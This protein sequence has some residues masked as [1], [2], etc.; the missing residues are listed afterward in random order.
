MAKDKEQTTG[1]TGV[2]E[3][4]PKQDTVVADIEQRAEAKEAKRW[5]DS[6]RI[7]NPFRRSHLSVLMDD[8]ARDNNVDREAMKARDFLQKQ[9][10]P[11]PTTLYRV[12]AYKA[13][14]KEVVGESQEIEAVDSGEAIRVFK[15][16]GPNK[17]NAELNK[18]S[19]RVEVTI[20]K[21]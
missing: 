2:M 7:P 10:L 3:A 1:E 17:D 21:A 11:N 8:Y 12:T 5:I 18:N 14:G 15:E 16:K 6:K 4:P 19:V 13:G 9:A 20:C